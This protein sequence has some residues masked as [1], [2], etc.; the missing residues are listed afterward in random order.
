MADSD[1]D[2]KDDDCTDSGSE[3][4][5]YGVKVEEQVALPNFKIQR[6]IEARAILEIIDRNLPR[7]LL[8]RGHTFNDAFT[9]GFDE[10]KLTIKVNL[11][12]GSNPITTRIENYFEL[13]RKNIDGIRE[14]LRQST[15]RELALLG[16]PLTALT[17]GLVV[18]RLFEETAGYIQDYRRF[19]ARGVQQNEKYWDLNAI[20]DV[21]DFFPLLDPKSNMR[22]VDLDTVQGTAT[23]IL[24]KT[25][26]QICNDILPDWR[27]LHCETVL[28]KDLKNNF[29]QYQTHLREDLMRFSYN[30]LKSFVPT[31]YRRATGNGAVAK[32][33]LVEYLTKPR[34]AFHG[35]RREVV[36]SIVQH[37]FL[38][39]G[40]IHPVTKKPMA[41]VNGAAYGQG[42]Y[43][44]PKPWYALLYSSSGPTALVELPG[45][46]LLVC[47][48][49]MGRTAECTVSNSASAS[50]WPTQTR[51]REGSDS[52][53]N[54]SGLAYILFNNTAI[55]PCYVLHLDWADK[56][57]EE[58]RNFVTTTSN[59]RTNRSSTS[60]S[61]YE[62]TMP[63]DRQRHKQEHLAKGKKF[64]AYGFGP[65]QGN[66]VVIEDVADV[67]DDE[68]DY[69][70]YQALRIDAGAD[71][72][73]KKNV[74][75]WGKMDGETAIDEYANARKAARVKKIEDFEDFSE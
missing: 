5:F 70:D 44:S 60:T 51:P 62:L 41:I 69:G 68:E 1:S 4:E 50:Y 46:K 33:Q 43:C 47:A 15:A 59:S 71:D 63:G 6:E 74:W 34:I 18:L 22:G 72:G 20:K 55:L 75:E 13:S 64:F 24:G 67:D 52:H 40:S 65:V 29:L 3:D 58:I 23:W 73:T 36:P 66:R 38:K 49:I 12:G 30:Q 57:G 42:I 7:E 26:A 31:A 2:R 14:A 27:I 25:P 39:P 35:T 19:C 45:Q 11:G 48:V 8:W 10:L 21:K 32:E 56:S 28:R 9:F 16:E 61:D 17:A 53:V 37:G 54:P